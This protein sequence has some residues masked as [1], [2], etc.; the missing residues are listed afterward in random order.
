MNDGFHLFGCKNGVVDLQSQTLLPPNRDNFVVSKMAV[1]FDPE[2]M[3]PRFLR[4]IE[5]ITDGDKHV[6]KYLQVIFGMM[7]LGKNPKQL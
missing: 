1:S 3:A 2:A 7:L 4:F 5:E 6:A